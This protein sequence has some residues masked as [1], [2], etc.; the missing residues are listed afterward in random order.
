MGGPGVDEGRGM[1]VEALSAHILYIVL[2][3]A[4]A[5]DTTTWIRLG[6]WAAPHVTTKKLH[7]S[8]EFFKK[9]KKKSGVEKVE[10]NLIGMK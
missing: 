2:A 8:N 5:T 9:E 6:F 4:A 10:L 1:M 3:A 7:R